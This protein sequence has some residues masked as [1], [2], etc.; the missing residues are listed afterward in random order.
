MRRKPLLAIAALPVL[1]GSAG[2]SP[3]A[4]QAQPRDAAPDAAPAL[5][6]LGDSLSD[7][8]NTAAFVDHLLGQPMYPEATVG[9]C[10]PGERLLL[11]RD[12]ADLLHERSRVSDGPVAVEHLAAHLGA[13]PFEPS[14]HTVPA[15]PVVGTNYAVAG[16][17]ARLETPR[18]LAHQ[19]DRLMLDHGPQLPARSAV[20]LMIGANDAIDALQ[21]A[22]LPGLEEPADSLPGSVD[23]PRI[24]PPDG[25]GRPDPGPIVAQALDAIVTAAARLLDAGACVI[26]ANAPS[27]ARLPAVSDTAELEGTDLATAMTA[28]EQVAT[29]FNAGLSERLAALGAAHP[30]GTS[31]VAFD[32]Y[33]RFKAALDA[34][35]LAGWNVADGCFDSERYTGST[36]GERSF[37]PRCAP[38]QDQAPAFEEFF[39]WDGIH[40]TGAAHA[41]LGA[42]LIEAYEAG[43]RGA[44]RAAVQAA[45]SKASTD[46]R[47]PGA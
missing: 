1:A 11:D 35:A 39:F 12:C 40:P 28:A 33:T 38:A 3:D 9:L 32:L 2:H 13:V 27:L 30:G 17:K 24:D 5:F 15:R 6:V 46:L 44:G 8:G 20:V 7:T 26:V 42:A 25:A 4:G 22:A 18:D 37:H 29:G 31:L 16:A 14:F 47:R 45:S 36:L 10:H 21:A 19:V 43:C 23:P 34:A 41:E